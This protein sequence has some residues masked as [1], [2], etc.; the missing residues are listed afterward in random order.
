M[1]KKL[2]E[3]ATTLPYSVFLS[4]VFALWI[5]ASGVVANDF[6]KTNINE[7]V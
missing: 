1:V 4:I 3:Q 7:R 6:Q 5:S 2:V